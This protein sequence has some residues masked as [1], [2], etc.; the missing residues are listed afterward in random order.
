MTEAAKPVPE[1]VNSTS[2]PNNVSAGQAST[3]TA[4]TVPNAKKAAEHAGTEIKT[5]VSAAL[6]NSSCR[7]AAVYAEIQRR[8]KRANKFADAIQ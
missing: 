6:P 1:T 8:T 3:E 5:D 7:K 2:N 4:K